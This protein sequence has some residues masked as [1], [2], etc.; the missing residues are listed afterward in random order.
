MNRSMEVELK[1]ELD[2]ASFERLLTMGRLSKR[3][4]QLNVY[5]DHDWLLAD[6][7]I[8]CRVRVAEGCAMLTVKIPRGRDGSSRAMLELEDV[9]PSERLAALR[10][11]GVLRSSVSLRDVLP[12]AI[13]EEIASL[14]VSEVA[15]VG[16]TRTT[17]YVLSFDELGELELDRVRLPGGKIAYEVEIEHTDPSVRGR[18]AE[19]VHQL[20]PEASPSSLSKFQ[21]FRL[22]LQGR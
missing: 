2:G 22:A 6:A 19:L 9:L 4:D 17:R 14:G 11:A 15:C 10:S 18:L 16:W 3:I 21:R 12:N 8:T 1:L 7:A 5:F 13:Q 20:A